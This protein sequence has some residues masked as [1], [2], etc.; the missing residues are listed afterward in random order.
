MVDEVREDGGEPT[1]EAKASSR[2][3]SRPGSPSNAPPTETLGPVDGIQ[4]TR[5]LDQSSDCADGPQR[6]HPSRTSGAT[7]HGHD[8]PKI[9]IRSTVCVS[10]VKDV[11]TPKLP[12]PPPRSAQKRS[13]LVASSHARTRPSAVT[14]VA[15]VSESHVRPKCR[16]VTPWPPPIVRPAMPTLPHVPPG[17]IAPAGASP[18]ATWISV[19]PAP[20]LAAPAFGRTTAIG[21]TSI[22]RP[23]QTEYPA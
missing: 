22:T 20:I 1:A 2:A 19:A 10:N 17:I 4:R 8:R 5:Q 7:D 3:S 21:E 23:S 18:A 15:A 9:V 16:P 12:P 13:G 14:T 6:S 11:T